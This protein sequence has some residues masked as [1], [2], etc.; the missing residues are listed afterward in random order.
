MHGEKS[1]FKHGEDSAE[2]IDLRSIPNL[3]FNRKFALIYRKAILFDLLLNPGPR[4]L[5]VSWTRR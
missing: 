3:C 1:A 4:P 2:T 5:A